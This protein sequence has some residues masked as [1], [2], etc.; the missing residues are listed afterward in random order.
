MEEWKDPTSLAKWTKWSLYA[1]VA[2]AFVSIIVGIFAFQ[3]VFIFSD[4]QDSV[5]MSIVILTNVVSGVLILTWIYRA[6]YNARQ[7]GASGITITPGWS[8]GWYFVPF[9]NLWMPY[10]AMKEIWKASVNPK[11]WSSEAVS[12][13]VPWWW[14]FWIVYNV[15]ANVSLRM[16]WRAEEIYEFN[17]AIVA[18]IIS[19]VTLMPLCFIF[20]AMI[21]RVH[22]MQ[23]SHARVRQD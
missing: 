13:L 11:S 14:F 3:L 16:A 2:L 21:N 1:E 5:F 20:I 8:V 19:G 6:N 18:G 12:S 17:N 9:A 10:L 4:I 15:F 7:L 22:G 23:L